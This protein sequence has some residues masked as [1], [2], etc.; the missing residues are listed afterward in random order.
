MWS[1]MWI[2]SGKGLHVPSSSRDGKQFSFIV[3]VSKTC[4]QCCICMPCMSQFVVYV[5]V[6]HFVPV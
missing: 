4:S 1:T 6:A 3:V 5:C 2:V